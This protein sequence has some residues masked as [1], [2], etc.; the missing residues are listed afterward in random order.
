MRIE[1]NTNS[2]EAHRRAPRAR[3][4][5]TVT[6]QKALSPG[7]W[8][9]HDDRSTGAEKGDAAFGRAPLLAGVCESL[10]CASFRVLP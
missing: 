6:K 4:L 8:A 3:F 1:L 10:G 5:S 7:F 9:P 2:R